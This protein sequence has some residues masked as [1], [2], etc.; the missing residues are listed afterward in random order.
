MGS[1]A[2][3]RTATEALAKVLRLEILTQGI[4]VSTIWPLGVKSGSFE[5]LEEINEE[6]ER[7][8]Q[9]NPGWAP[10]RQIWQAFQ[11]FQGGPGPPERNHTSGRCRPRC[12]AGSHGEIS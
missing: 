10:Y 3:S 9:N 11:K 2:L 4:S 12:P 5:S 7:N 6:I 1:N 8:V